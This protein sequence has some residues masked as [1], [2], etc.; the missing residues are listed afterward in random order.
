MPE[1]NIMQDMLQ[2]ML[3]EF[4]EQLDNTLPGSQEEKEIKEQIEQIEQE[5]QGEGAR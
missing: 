5:I 3:R 1:H 2:R 4:K